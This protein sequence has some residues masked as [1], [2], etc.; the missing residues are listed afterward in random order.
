M[1]EP[2][3]LVELIGVFEQLRRECPWKAAQTHESL[4]RY[5][6][7]EA[8]EAVEAIES[9]DLDA[10][11]DELGDVLL[12]VYL[13]AEIAA[14]DGAFDVEDVAA[15]LR[16]KMIRRNPH[17][18]GDEQELARTGDPAAIN[19]RWQQIKAE[20]QSRERLLDGVPVA[21][22]ALQRAAKLVDRAERAG[23]PVQVDPASV[24]LGERLLGLVIAA[25]D[26][27]VDPETALRT[28]VRRRE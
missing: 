16:D 9:G 21:L 4:T 7:E 15:G 14:Q 13:Q 19:E 20:E 22:P 8:Y 5:L 6:I 3:P 17:V 27:G 25:H 26:A 2:S 1:A 28:A 23:T 10:M 11:R 18:F 12:Q 24:E